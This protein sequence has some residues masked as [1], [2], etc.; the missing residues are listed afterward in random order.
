MLDTNILL[1]ATDEGR[2]GHGDFARFG[3]HVQVSGLPG[4]E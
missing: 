2:A 1:T 4:D 3:Q